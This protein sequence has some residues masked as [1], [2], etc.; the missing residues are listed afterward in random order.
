MGT[1]LITFP[2]RLPEHPNISRGYEML[3]N[4]AARMVITFD[5]EEAKDNVKAPP[6]IRK[7]SLA[8][9]IAFSDES[10]WEN[11][12][13]EMDDVEH[14]NEPVIVPVSVAVAVAAPVPVPTITGGAKSAYADIVK[15]TA[16]PLAV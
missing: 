16:A 3:T 2:P 9:S 14:T 12:Q 10:E 11:V 7:D 4:P 15:R 1:Q 13:F 5:R 6:H 8:A